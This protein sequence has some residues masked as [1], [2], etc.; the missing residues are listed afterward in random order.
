MLIDDLK[1]IAKELLVRDGNHQP[2]FMLC[3]DEQI[4]GEPLPTMMFD[5]FYKDDLNAEDSK[6]RSVYCMGVLAKKLGA[7]RLV[8]IWDA[9]LRLMPPN[10]KKEDIDETELPLQ[11]PKSMRTECLIITDISFVTGGDVTH[12][13]PY[14]G[15]EGVPVEFLDNPYEGKRLEL[16][17]TEVALRGYNK[18]S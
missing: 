15:G 16:R 12:A 10:T 4:I 11:Y 2:I 6:S 14:K 1:Q 7:N 17:F 13:I 3:S 5:M 9:A 18:D 8:M